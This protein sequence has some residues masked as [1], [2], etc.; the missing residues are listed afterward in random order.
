MHTQPGQP[1]S[2]PLHAAGA[3]SAIQAATH[4]IS[5]EEYGVPPSGMRAPHEGEHC[6]RSLAVLAA[7]A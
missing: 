1:Q 5:S 6:F 7:W 2:R 3:S 4:A